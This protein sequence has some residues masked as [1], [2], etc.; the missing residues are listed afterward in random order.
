MT[1]NPHSPAKHKRAPGTDELRAAQA[2]ASLFM[3]RCDFCRTAVKRT[4]EAGGPAKRKG[5][6][7][8]NEYFYAE[9]NACLVKNAEEYYRTMC[10]D[11][12]LCSSPD[13][14]GSSASKA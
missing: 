6:A 7:E 3:H 4:R 1:A 10:E 14:C 9:Q 5:N 12:I 13:M 8:A 11:R 2:F